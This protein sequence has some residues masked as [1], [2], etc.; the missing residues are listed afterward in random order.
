MRS[1]NMDQLALKVALE[2]EQSDLFARMQSEFWQALFCD[3]LKEENIPFTVSERKVR[4]MPDLL[5]PTMNS[6]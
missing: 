1:R 4:Y 6:R 2:R 3:I 5:L